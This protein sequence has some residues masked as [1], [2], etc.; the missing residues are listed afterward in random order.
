MSVFMTVPSGSR[1]PSG[2]SRDVAQLPVSDSEV[3]A[4]F[5]DL[6]DGVESGLGE[7]RAVGFELIGS[8]L[9]ELIRYKSMPGPVGY[10][11]RLDAASPREPSLSTVAAL[12]GVS[13]ESLPW[14]CDER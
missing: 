1:W 10:I 6:L 7:W 11:L 8:S 2:R 14:V 5:G 4:V 9:V 12:L 13:L 3:S